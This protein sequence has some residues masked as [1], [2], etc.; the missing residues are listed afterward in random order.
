MRLCAVVRIEW[1]CAV[2]TERAYFS[3]YY[4]RADNC[5]I[6]FA[7]SQ[8]TI[9]LA[10]ITSDLALQ[11]LVVSCSTARNTSTDSPSPSRNWYAGTC[12]QMYSDA[13]SNK[14]QVGKDEWVTNKC[15]GLD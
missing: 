1:K 5:G 15:A 11:A 3:E 2:S 8:S 13:V 9:T 7:T 14:C 4:P 12:L 10:C 6:V